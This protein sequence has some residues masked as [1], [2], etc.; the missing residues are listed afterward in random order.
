M[1]E[2]K[3]YAIR[4]PL[5]LL[6]L[7]A[8]ASSASFRVC[9]PMLPV[10]ARLFG[11]TSG[12][13]ALVI[14]VFTIAYGGMQL[15]Y[16]PLGELMD[17]FRVITLA[18]ACC[19]LGSL[20]AAVTQSLDWLIA[21]RLLT[22]VAAAGI[23]PLSMAWIA[24]QV[25][26]H[27]RQSV[28][29]QF[30]S[31][32]IMGMVF[33]QMLGGFFVDA[34]VWRYAF[35]SL[36]VLYVFIAIALWRHIVNSHSED[37][38]KNRVTSSL[39]SLYLTAFRL[40]LARETRGVLFCFLIE[41]ALVFAVIAFMPLYLHEHF[42][43]ALSKASLALGLYGLGGLLF[44]V[45]TAKMGAKINHFAFPMMAACL[46]AVANFI[47]FLSSQEI[48]IFAAAVL[49]GFGFY[50]LHNVLLF[51]MTQRVPQSRSLAISLSVSIFF[52]GQSLGV[53][54][55][56]WLV[57]QG[58]I[59]LIFLGAAMGMPVIGWFTGRRVRAF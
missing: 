3:T 40:L 28:L 15:I 17:R 55:A 16:G 27:Q 38:D 59:H 36:S 5:I 50:M 56:G 32:Q 51:Q 58:L 54:F 4:R 22:G 13:V 57:D 53:G 14:T 6:M 9:D 25:D 42:G 7:A 44:S 48:W 49:S 45:F 26:T 20:G 37:R 52:V 12:Q 31:G 39:I 2:D 46:V 10:L 30:F 47:A 1:N 8:F 35:F 29:A 33:G 34:G 21:C 41:A 19:A 18:T 24:D 23:I 11:Q 43:V